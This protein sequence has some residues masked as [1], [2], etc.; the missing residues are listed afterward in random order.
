MLPRIV[1]SLALFAAS[2]LFAQT[3]EPIIHTAAD[4]QHSKPNYSKPPRQAPPA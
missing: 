3:T 1:L 2:P 4:L